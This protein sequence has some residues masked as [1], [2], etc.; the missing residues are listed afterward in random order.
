[1]TTTSRLRQALHQGRTRLQI[2][3][4]RFGLAWPLVFMMAATALAVHA[5]LLPPERSALS[6]TQA[7]LAQASSRTAGQPSR[8]QAPNGPQAL[9]TLLASAPAPEVQLQVM[10]ARAASEQ[11]QLARADYSLRPVP[12]LPVAQW[13]VTQP[14][15]ARYPQLRRYIEAVLRE[16][17][18]ASLDQVSVRRDSAGVEDLDV[19]LQWSLWLPA[20]LTA[21]PARASDVNEPV[22]DLIPRDVLLP[23]R[24]APPLRDLF[25]ARRWTPEPS[26][27]A[28]QRPAAPAPPVLP[29]LPY[30]FIGKKLQDGR[31]E[32]YVTRGEQSLVL[33]EGE[34]VDGQWRVDRIAP[35]QL[36]LTYLPLGQGNAQVL[37]IGDDR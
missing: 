28:T 3:A 6:Q 14:V 25:A 4:W 5:L 23:T 8:P 2:A 7:R 32:V 27:M 34:V 20:P 9:R 15:R 11:V 13:Q 10:G 1:M 37:P 33:R 18:H 36:S 30:T 16:L 31:W 22:L 26:P 19:R 35:P 17:P 29:P 21:A 12:G 24:E